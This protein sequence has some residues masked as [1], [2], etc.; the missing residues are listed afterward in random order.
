MDRHSRGIGGSFRITD[1]GELVAESP[2]P[3]AEIDAPPAVIDSSDSAAPA[4]DDKKTRGK[5]K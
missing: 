3:D 4:A 2:A 1:T 5:Q